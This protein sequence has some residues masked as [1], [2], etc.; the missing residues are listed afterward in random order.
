[1]VPAVERHTPS[2]PNA[3][4]ALALSSAKTYAELRKIVD[5]AEA[6]KILHREVDG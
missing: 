6:L 5:T 2:V 4:K 3:L 1:V